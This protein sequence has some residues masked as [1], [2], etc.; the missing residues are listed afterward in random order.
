MQPAKAILHRDYGLNS[1]DADDVVMQALV[2]TCTQRPL[3]EKLEAYFWTVA[4]RQ[5]QRAVGSARRMVACDSSDDPELYT[6]ASRPPEVREYLLARLWERAMCELNGR[7]AHVLR[8]RFD[9]DRS[10]RAV[11]EQ[12]GM[13]EERAKNLFHN[14]VKKLRRRLEAC[15]LD[16]E[17]EP[18]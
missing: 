13:S 16:L 17:L 5:G 3:P 12:L 18:E 11:G 14:A 4:K 7:E 2:T 9:G 15:P 6:C 8:S 1:F 10:F